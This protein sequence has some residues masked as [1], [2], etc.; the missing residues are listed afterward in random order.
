MLWVECQEKAS[1]RRWFLNK[2]LTNE[3]VRRCGYK[4][5]SQ[6]W[7]FNKEHDCQVP[8]TAE[9]HRGGAE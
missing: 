1:L 4:E 6:L 9:G 2:D 3:G 5:K 8:G 7:R